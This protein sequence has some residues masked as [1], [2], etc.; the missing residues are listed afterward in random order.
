MSLRASYDNFT[1]VLNDP[2]FQYTISRGESEPYPCHLAIVKRFL[3]KFPTRNRTYIDVGAHIGTT[4]LPYSRLFQKCIGYEANPVNFNFCK[5]NIE[6]NNVKN[7]TV[8]NFAVSHEIV[9]GNVILHEGGNSGCFYFKESTSGNIQSVRLDDEPDL[10]NVD[11]IKIDTEGS[12]LNVLK[13]CEVILLRDKPLIHVETN[14]CSQKYFNISIKELY[15][16]LYSLG[17]V[18]FDDSDNN[19]KFFSLNQ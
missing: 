17:Y 8:K 5:L 2:I 15:D 7:A 3:E 12:E 14:N 9:K 19:N 10:M 4:I 1:Y 18:L 16:Y 11:F 6:K 13:S